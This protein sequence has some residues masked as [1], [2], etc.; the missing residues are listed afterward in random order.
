[1]FMDN[2]LA[3]GGYNL[4]DTSNL[5]NH[6]P[7]SLDDLQTYI[8][9]TMNGMSYHKQSGFMDVPSMVPGSSEYPAPQHSSSLSAMPDVFI[10]LGSYQD[11]AGH[12]LGWNM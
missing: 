4:K 9:L 1:M 7:S 3:Y 5:Q 2:N 10:S 8:P 12:M 6:I 11:N